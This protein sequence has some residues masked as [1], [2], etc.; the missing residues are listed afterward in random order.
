MVVGFRVLPLMVGFWKSCA[1]SLLIS[2]VAWGVSLTW[3][4]T[5]STNGSMFTD[6]AGEAMRCEDSVGLRA[7]FIRLSL[8]GS[9]EILEVREKASRQVSEVDPQV[10][11]PR[12]AGVEVAARRWAAGSLARGRLG[13]AAGDERVQVV[14]TPRPWFMRA[15]R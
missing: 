13:R 8:S 4:R 12:A 10:L 11:G 3:R 7:V 9:L 5:T 2:R 1:N 6:M 15:L 14:P